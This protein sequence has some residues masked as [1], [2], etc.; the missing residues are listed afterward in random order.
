[1]LA[2]TLE[3]AGDYEGASLTL[4]DLWRG[5]G[6]RP[7]VEGFQTG[8]AALVLLRVGS[9]SGWLG[10]VGQIAGAQDAAKDI[11]GE[12]WRVFDELGDTVM[13][14]EAAGDL[15][16]CYWREGAFDEARIHLRQALEKLSAS[17]NTPNEAMEVESH[18]VTGE[19]KTTTAEEV[20]AVLL[21]RSAIVEFTSN[22]LDESLRLLTEVAPLIVWNSNHVLRGKYHIHLAMTLEKMGTGGKPGNAES[23][24]DFMDRALVEYSAAGFHFEQAGHARYA[25]RVEN[26]L[27]MLFLALNRF[28]DSHEHLDRAERFFRE[29]DDLGSVAQITETRA[30][31]LLTEGRNREAERAAREAVEMLADGGEQALVAEALTT[32]G[33][34]LARWGCVEEARTV[35]RQAIEV[36]SGA[37]DN[38]GAGR[39]GLSLLEELGAMLEIT[40]RLA[41]QSEVDQLLS[42]STHA[43]TLGRLRKTTREIITKLT[44]EPGNTMVK[45]VIEQPAVNNGRTGMNLAEALRGSTLTEEIKRYEGELI[46]Q[47]LNASGGSVTHAAR[48][49]GLSHQSLSFILHTRH[50]ALSTELKPR[51][52]RQRSIIGVD[53]KNAKVE[54]NSSV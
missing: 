16:L 39:A 43:E 23:H 27:G 25:A 47:A 6:N 37:G 32:R 36:A 46:K 34:A 17:A 40:E 22:R 53:V 42:C 30:R 1:M 11:I 14:A 48:M 20:R 7:D 49:L 18:D 8:I 45:S 24:A 5:V 29:L 2:K 44:V 3:E 21:I 31:V 4:G 26:N 33:V 50:Q 41:I 13:N 12:A 10:S 19:R 35:F 9:L 38:E 52:R 15:A 51:K 54:M 28:A